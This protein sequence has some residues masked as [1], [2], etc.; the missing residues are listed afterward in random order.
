MRSLRL[1]LGIFTAMAMAC[2]LTG[3]AVASIGP[4]GGR[5][6]SLAIDPVHPNILYAGSGRGGIYQ[7]TDA[8]A[9]WTLTAW[10]T[11]INGIVVDPQDPNTLYIA[12]GTVRKSMDGERVG[13]RWGT[14]W[15]ARLCTR[16]QSIPT[17]R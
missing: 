16:W 5:V 6:D 12:E 10:R 3:A 4:F 1:M 7:S 11:G 2:L 13:E 8:A 14:D 17:I 9:R 15:L